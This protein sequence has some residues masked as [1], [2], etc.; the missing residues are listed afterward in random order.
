MFLLKIKKMFTDLIASNAPI[1]D[2][3]GETAQISTIRLI[4]FI[5][6]NH[7]LKIEYF[8]VI[9]GIGLDILRKAVHE[10]LKKNNLVI[11]FKLDMFNPG[12]TIVKLE[13]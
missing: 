7:K 12:C 11:D 6:E 9:H 13:H 2:L 1:L 8:I 5:K 4:D 10:E 3:H